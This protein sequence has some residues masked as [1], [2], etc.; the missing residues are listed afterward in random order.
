MGHPKDNKFYK[1]ANSQN[2]VRNGDNGSL[3]FM[4]TYYSRLKDSI[5][6]NTVLKAI[7]LQKQRFHWYLHLLYHKNI[8]QT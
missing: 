5:I 6:Q 1:I 4:L 8:V 2:E 7:I 3:K